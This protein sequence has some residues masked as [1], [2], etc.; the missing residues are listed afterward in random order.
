MLFS[1]LLTLSVQPALAWSFRYWFL[2]DT[3][4]LV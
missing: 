4:R 1:L 2:I 3:R